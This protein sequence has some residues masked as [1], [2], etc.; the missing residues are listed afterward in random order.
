[1][2]ATARPWTRHPSARTWARTARASTPERVLPGVAG[3]LRQRMRPTILFVEGLNPAASCSAGGQ[4]VLPHHADAAG[5]A[6]GAHRPGG[7]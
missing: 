1:M 6:Q 2:Q 3:E 7:V 5:V 4:G